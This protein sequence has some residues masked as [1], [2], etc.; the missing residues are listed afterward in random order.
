MGENL[1]NID[2]QYPLSPLQAFQISLSS[3]GYKVACEWVEEIE[4]NNK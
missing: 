3:F 1:F 4:L 2:F